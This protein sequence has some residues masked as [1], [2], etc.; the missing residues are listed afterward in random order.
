[1]GQLIIVDELP[2]GCIAKFVFFFIAKHTKSGVVL[3]VLHLLVGWVSF[4]R[5][6]FLALLLV[7][8]I[9]N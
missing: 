1:V 8:P 4:Y 6:W 9:Y 7:P 5:V 2:D 3:F